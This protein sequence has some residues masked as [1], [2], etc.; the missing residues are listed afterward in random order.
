MR[1]PNLRA[2]KLKLSHSEYITVTYLE[3]KKIRGNFL[4]CNAM[5]SKD[6][7]LDKFPLRCASI[8]RLYKLTLSKSSKSV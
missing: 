7:G 1:L 8:M 5:C 2:S 6:H 4:A 3:K